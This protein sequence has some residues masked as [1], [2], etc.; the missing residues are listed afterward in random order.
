[1]DTFIVLDNI[2]RTLRQQKSR[3]KQSLIVNSD[4]AQQIFYR[5]WSFTNVLF[6]QERIQLEMDF[7]TKNNTCI[8]FQYLINERRLLRQLHFV[9]TQTKNLIQNAIQGN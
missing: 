9:C 1:M 7:V 5:F 6:I 2:A 4:I 8:R 3:T